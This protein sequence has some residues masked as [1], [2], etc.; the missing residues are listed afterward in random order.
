MIELRWLVKPYE[1]A[2]DR[3]GA[4]VVKEGGPVL[5]YRRVTGDGGWKEGD[6]QDVPMQIE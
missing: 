6:W 2:Y 3:D 4:A 5:Q 1:V